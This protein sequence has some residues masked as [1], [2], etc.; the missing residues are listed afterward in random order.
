MCCTMTKTMRRKKYTREQA[1]RRAAELYEGGIRQEVEP[2]FVGKYLVMDLDSGEYA[3][4]DTLMAASDE[5]RRTA[6]EA[7]QFAIRIGHPAAVRIGG[8]SS[9]KAS[10]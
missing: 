6:P 5:M 8:S 1:D 10:A 4:A 7:S 9:A 3:I 2:S